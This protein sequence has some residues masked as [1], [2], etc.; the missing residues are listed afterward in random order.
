MFRKIIFFGHFTR[1][2]F[3]VPLCNKLVE[4][5]F[6]SNCLVRI[7]GCCNKKC[8]PRKFPHCYI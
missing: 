5:H 3:V 1:L 2:H 7:F 6:Y 4:I 8:F